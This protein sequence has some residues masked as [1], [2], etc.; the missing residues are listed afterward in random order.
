MYMGDEP[1]TGS[2][3]RAV[4]E[5]AEQQH[6]V[7]SRGEL[8]TWTERSD[9]CD[10]GGVW[11][12]AP[13]VAGGVRRRPSWDWTTGRDVRGG[14]CLRGRRGGVAWERGGAAWAVGEGL[15][16]V[17]VIGRVKRGEKSKGCTGIE[18]PAG[19]RGDRVP[20]RIPC[21]TVSRTLVDLAGV[22][23]RVVASGDR[24]GRGGG[25]AGCCRYRPR[26]R[27]GAQA[28]RSELRRILRVW[29]REEGLPKLRSGIEARVLAACVEAASSAAMQRGVAA[30]RKTP[31]G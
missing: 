8:P 18:L 6:G 28:G 17:D 20:R 13:C 11:V 10:A 25:A 1:N 16:V 14:A 12:A 4:A 21:T 24:A 26:A 30:G 5:F 7:V 29:R 27:A 31:R 22:W 23:G 2:G 19:A 3:N 9:D 15:A